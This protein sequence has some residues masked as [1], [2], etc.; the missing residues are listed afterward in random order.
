[1]NAT[2]P[3]NPHPDL[4]PPPGAGTFGWEEGEPPARVV[5]DIRRLED[6]SVS[7]LLHATQLADGC[8]DDGSVIEAPGISVDLIAE[9]VV[10]AIDI[11]LSVSGARVLAAAL[12][13]AADAIEGWAGR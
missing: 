5:Y 10:C 7:L 9:G 11:R 13:A 8:F 6:E 3:M 2:A 1:M 12:T 4:A